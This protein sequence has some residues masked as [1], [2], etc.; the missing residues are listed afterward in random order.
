MTNNLFIS[1][2]Q[3]NL[4][5]EDKEAN[6][7]NFESLF[8]KLPIESQI[9]VLPEMFSTGF[10]MNPQK[11]A[12][13]F[14][15]KTINWLKNQANKA[16]KIII[17]SIIITDNGNN[18]NRLVT[19]FPNGEILFYDKRHLFRMAGEHNH[20]SSGKN[21]LIFTLDNWNI[22]PLICYDLRFP[23][24]SRNKNNY[25]VLIYI[26]NWPEARSYAWKNLL[27]ARAIENQCF[28]IGVNRVGIDG[29][30]I[31][32]TGDSMIINPYGQI[33]TQAKANEEQILS[34]EL[35]FDEI[36]S[37]RKKF[38]AHL[39]ADDFEINI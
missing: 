25:N 12:E 22:C 37:I 11:F 23:V 34:A 28:V 15:G 31:K 1:C 21:K 4:I 6:F 38:P 18:Y 24:W 30:N 2:I 10:S 9:V 29:N 14:D 3:T 35:S 13:P 8:Q 5:W 16:N 17:G 26:A 33:I 32:H 39:D 36:E 19:V 20:Y 27:I 7:T